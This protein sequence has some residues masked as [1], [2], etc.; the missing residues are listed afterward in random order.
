[1]ELLAFYGALLP[2]STYCNDEFIF[3]QQ[4]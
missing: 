2:A 4:W 3:Y 1:M